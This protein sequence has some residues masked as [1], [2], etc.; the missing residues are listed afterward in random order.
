[1]PRGLADSILV[2]FDPLYKHTCAVQ[3][4]PSATRVFSRDFDLLRFPSAF[5]LAPFSVVALV[6]LARC[7]ADVAVCR[8]PSGVDCGVWYIA[9][10]VLGCLAN[11]GSFYLLP[12]NEEDSYE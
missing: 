12:K 7:F 2:C 6:C 11:F 8:L 4:A 1:M 9:I 5:C 10:F 3:V